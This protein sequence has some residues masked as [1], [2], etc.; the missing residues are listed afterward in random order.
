MKKRKKMS[1]LDQ[2]V[3]GILGIVAVS[4]LAIFATFYFVASPYQK[5]ERAAI[6]I[7]KEKTSLK[8]VKTFEIVTTDVSVYSLTG[9]DAAGKNIAVLLPKSGGAIQTISLENGKKPTTTDPLSVGWYKNQ[10]VWESN[11]PTAFKL[12]DFK[13]GKQIY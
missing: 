4:F 3:M 9:E 1:V 5:T 2:L 6:A 13:T 11:T 10:P 8:T 7:A 12:Y